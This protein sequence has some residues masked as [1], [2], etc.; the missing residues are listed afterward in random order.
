MPEDGFGA[1]VWQPVAWIRE[2]KFVGIQRLR[3]MTDS[4][5]NRIPPCTSVEGGKVR[6]VV[7]F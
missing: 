2:V 4:C 7:F 5:K 6:F 3:S 1:A